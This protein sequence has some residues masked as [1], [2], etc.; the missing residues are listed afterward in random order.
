MR[1]ALVFPYGFETYSPPVVMA[2]LYAIAK[3]HGRTKVFDFSL[4]SHSPLKLM[5]KTFPKL[6][7]QLS[8]FFTIR[9]LSN[10]VFCGSKLYKFYIKNKF[11]KKIRKR[12]WNKH[13]NSSFEK[14]KAFKPDVICLSLPMPYCYPFARRIAE[15]YKKFDSNCK[16]VYGG[17]FVTHLFRKI[18]ENDSS[19][20]FVIP[21][22]ND[23]VLDNLLKN[24]KSGKNPKPIKGLA[25]IE[26]NKVLYTRPNKK[27]MFIIP[28]FSWANWEDYP[29]KTLSYGLST[30]CVHNCKFCT[31]KS[32]WEG[33]EELS[34]PTHIK[35][36][37]QICKDSGMDEVDFTDSSLNTPKQRMLDVC[38]EINRQG[39]N[40]RWSA[41]FRAQNFD[42]TIIKELEESGCYMACIGVESGSDQIL[43]AMNKGLTKEEIYRGL[44]PFKGSKIQVPTTWILGFPGETLNQGLE[45]LNFALKLLNKGFIHATSFTAGIKIDTFNYQRFKEHLKDN[46][47][48]IVFEE[49]ISDDIENHLKFYW[50]GLWLDNNKLYTQKIGVTK[51]LMKLYSFATSLDALTGYFSAYKKSFGL[52][53][54]VL[55][56][57]IKTS[58]NRLI[59]SFKP[60]GV[61]KKEKLTEFGPFLKS[62][63]AGKLI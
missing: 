2:H 46:S 40:V 12:L 58:K 15:K 7:S 18:L 57:V 60:L 61:E 53:K 6:A 50:K 39:L 11:L 48:K 28:D 3:K 25:Y 43:K 24:L 5:G 19:V 21:G 33:Y 20:D 8:Y 49:L 30:G 51:D 41:S 62:L 47:E 1:I 31:N 14:V 13:L 63:E 52:K 10:N 54:I 23:S 29:N 27:E 45:S 56:S 4:P 59:K 22:T 32:Y 9:N 36:V 34:L 35:N 37:K 42:K 44:A 17:Y 38:A 16:I 26:K 55:K